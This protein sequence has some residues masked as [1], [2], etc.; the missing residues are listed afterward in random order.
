M[1][2][3][4]AQTGMTEH[5]NHIIDPSS[6]IQYELYNTIT[7]Y[8]YITSYNNNNVIHIMY[9]GCALASCHSILA[10]LCVLRWLML[11]GLLC[12]KT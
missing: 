5:I 7:H 9:V 10:C 4:R 12:S 3:A 11:R 6:N 8:S 2:P 1:A